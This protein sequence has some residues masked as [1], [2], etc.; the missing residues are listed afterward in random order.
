MYQYLISYKSQFHV[1]LIAMPAQKRTRI[2]KRL[3]TIRN[4]IAKYPGKIMQKGVISGAIKPR[5]ARQ[6]N[7][8][9]RSPKRTKQISSFTV[10]CPPAPDEKLTH[11]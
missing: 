4:S 2:P 10:D 5:C 7:T 9:V 3:I 1:W 8:Q 6:S 11:H